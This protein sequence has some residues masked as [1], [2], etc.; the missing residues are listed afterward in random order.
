MITKPNKHQILFI[1]FSL[2]LL[3]GSI[4]SQTL[5]YDL[6]LFETPINLENITTSKRVIFLSLFLI[7]T[8]GIAHGAMDGKIIWEYSVKKRSRF[9]LYGLY[10]L[11]VFFGAIFWLY[12]PISG[13]ALLLFLSCIHFGLSDL[14]IIGKGVLIPKICW[15]FTMTFLPLLFKPVLVNDLFYDLTLT[16]ISNEIFASIR[17]LTIISI[18]I[19]FSYLLFKLFKQTEK[20]NSITF[21]LILFEFFILISLAYYLDPLIWFALYFCGLHGLRAILVLNFKLIPDIFWVMLFTS[22][23]TIF[24]FLNNS[25]YASSDLLVIFPVLASLTIAHMLLPKLKKLIKA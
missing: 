23:I 15:G 8:L 24:I 13:L 22:P 20:N 17:I 1:F 2:I 19:F 3:F 9:G 5:N 16:N 6:N 12:S 11:L 14:S 7:G 18:L 25:T 21:K 4:T 10:A